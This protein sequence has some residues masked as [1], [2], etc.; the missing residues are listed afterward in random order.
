MVDSVPRQFDKKK[1]L[2]ITGGSRG[3]GLQ[4]VKDF[5]ENDYQVISVSR[6][7]PK[8]HK[9]KKNFFSIQADLSSHESLDVIRDYLNKK[10]IKIDTLINNVGKSQWKSLKNINREFINVYIFYW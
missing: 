9:N 7:I 5:L 3:I 8:I 4:I 6:T 2:F 1:I 10:K